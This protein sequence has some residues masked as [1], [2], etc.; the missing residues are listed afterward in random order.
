MSTPE[1]KAATEYAGGDGVLSSDMR[2]AFLAG[3]KWA[4]ENP[5]SC[6]ECARDPSHSVICRGTP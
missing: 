3:V 1:E 6:P 4:R 2:D 5:P